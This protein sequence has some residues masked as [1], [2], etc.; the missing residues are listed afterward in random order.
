MPQVAYRRHVALRLRQTELRARDPSRHRVT[1]GREH[2]RQP[3]R[4]VHEDDEHT[5]RAR[6]QPREL[7]RPEQGRDPEHEHRSEHC[8]GQGAEPTDDDEEQHREAVGRSEVDAA[9]VRPGVREYDAGDTGH[10]AGDREAHEPRPRSRDPG[11]TCRGV[12][13]AD[14]DE[15]AARPGAAQVRRKPQT[16]E[17]QQQAEVV[18][19]A[20]AREDARTCDECARRLPNR[21]LLQEHPARCED[22]ERERRD[23]EEQP[24]D[25]Q[26]RN[27]D[28]DRGNGACNGGDND[29]DRQR[30]I[31]AESRNDERPDT[32]ERV[33]SERHLS[34][35]A[36]EDRQRH[37]GDRE[38]HREREPEG[39]LARVE[40]GD[41]WQDDGHDEHR[42]QSRAPQALHRLRRGELACERGE[43]RAEPHTCLALAQ[44]L[45]QLPSTNEQ[46]DEDDAEH[47]QIGEAAVERLGE[48]HVLR[49][50]D[51]HRRRE[52]D[53]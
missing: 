5:D 26:R 33:L 17:Q 18:D 19:G 29:H 31:R 45:R 13:V 6:H 25:P 41:E 22:G 23:G 48:D 43:L 44:A 14:G 38:A 52:S 1:R 15:Q 4:Q 53:G 36:C 9:E 20:F 2:A 30:R 47:D 21:P 7:A 11:R 35:P 50:A 27:A 32:D 49:D 3:T 37:T 10:R 42:E 40:S 12:V 51:H 28:E 16:H 39:L 46:R 8:T 34:R 24:L